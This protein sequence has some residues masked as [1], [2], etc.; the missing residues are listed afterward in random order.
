MHNKLKR[1]NL[2]MFSILLLVLFT[3]PFIVLADKPLLVNGIPL[4]YLYILIVWII[5]IVFLYRLTASKKKKTD[6]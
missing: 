5:A 3:Y 6:E 2:T 1:Q 4:L